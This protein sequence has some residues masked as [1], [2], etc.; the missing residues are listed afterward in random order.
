M[1]VPVRIIV[2]ENDQV[3]QAPYHQRLFGRL[4]C[5]K[6][7]VVVPGAGH[8]LPL[9]HLETTAGLVAEWFREKLG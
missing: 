4:R 3:L 5:P 8:M 1:Q 6:D 9:E 2:G 7:L